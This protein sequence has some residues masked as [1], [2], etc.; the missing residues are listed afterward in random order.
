MRVQGEFPRQS[1]SSVF[2]LKEV[3]NA[4]KT[5]V[6]DDS[7]AE[8]WALDV[9]DFG[10]DKSCLAK[11]KGFNFHYLQ[12]RSNLSQ[13][14]LA[15]WLIY[16]YNLAKVKPKIIFVDTIGV[17]AGLPSIAHEKGLTVVV[18][19]KGSSRASN[20]DKYFNKRAELYYNL[21][22][23]IQNSK[24]PDDDELIGELMAQKYKISTTGTLQ[25]VSKDEIKKELGR[26]PDK[27]D[28]LSM[29]C[30]GLV[31]YTETEEMEEV[32]QGEVFYNYSGAV[33]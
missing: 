16:E 30:E 5:A 15:G 17:G 28:A 4:T 13:T 22:S 14:E 27:A 24:L 18:G 2:A 11:R 6:F 20:S 31:F 29:T 10:D 3:E 12:T 25:L 33:W 32:A 23:I 9:A 21:H 8:I 26:S 19:I 7:G 1:S